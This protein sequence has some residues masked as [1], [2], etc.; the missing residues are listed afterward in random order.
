MG[1][2]DRRTKRGK[3][4]KQSYGKHRPAKKNQPAYIAKPSVH[5]DII[6]KTAIGKVQVAAV[7]KEKK[8]VPPKVEKKAVA[9]KKPKVAKLEE[10]KEKILVEDIILQPEKKEAAPKKAPAEKKVV[11]AKKTS[12]DKKTP[13]TK[14]A[15][16]KKEAPVKKVAPAAKKPAVAA[17]KASKPKV[18]APK[19]KPV[20]KKAK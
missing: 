20:T 5:E 7:I 3:I 19:E 6:E 12:T 15:P 1:R 9:E 13:V 16:D 10:F 14:A 4:F 2:G 8:V 11:A 17:P 18:V